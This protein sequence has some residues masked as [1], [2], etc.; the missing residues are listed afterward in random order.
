VHGITGEA[1]ATPSIQR[2]PSLVGC[3]AMRSHMTPKAIGDLGINEMWRV[4]LLA[5]Q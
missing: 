5:C 4:Q 3:D 1:Q 2:S